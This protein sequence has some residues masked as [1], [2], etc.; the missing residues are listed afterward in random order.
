SKLN[1]IPSPAAS[2]FSSMPVLP[3][4]TVTVFSPELLDGHRVL[5]YC[6]TMRLPAPGAAMI[7]VSSAASI[8]PLS[9]VSKLGRIPIVAAGLMPCVGAYES[10]MLISPECH[11]GD[12]Q[13]SGSSCTRNDNSTPN[14][15]SVHQ[16][17]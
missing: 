16:R 5:R 3:H 1:A 10:L 4:F 9:G 8:A 13:S 12:Y 14:Q 7:D 15:I 11:G 17:M 6:T 2:V